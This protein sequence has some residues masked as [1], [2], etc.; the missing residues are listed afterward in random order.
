M[1]D[2]SKEI[3]VT[4]STHLNLVDINKTKNIDGLLKY[5][6]KKENENLCHKNG[7]VLKDTLDIINRS[8]G[9]LVSHNN[10]SLIEY[11]VTMKLDVV[12]PSPDD[13]FEV[14]IDS[15]TKMGIIG[16]LNDNDYTIENS[17]LLFIIPNKYIKDIDLLKK[18]MIIQVVVL[19]S[20]IKYKSKQ[21]QVVGKISE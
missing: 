6:L 9:K 13:I 18:D 7:F 19:Q 11:N 1:K 5:K 4:T 15:I 17:P 8:I 16:Y 14:K 2:Y 10:L 20:R 3:I 21:I 12:Y